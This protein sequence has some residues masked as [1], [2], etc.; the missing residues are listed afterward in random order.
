MTKLK[1]IIGLCIFG[2]IMF[3]VIN[4]TVHLKSKKHIYSNITDVP[5]C[6]TGIVLGAMVSHSGELSYILKDRVDAAIDLYKVNKIQRFLLSGDHGL[7]NYDEVNSMKIY[8]LEKGI[9]TC[10]IFLDHAGFDT[11]SSLTR[12]KE[13]FQVKNAIIISQRFHLP[14]AVYI[15]RKKGINAHGFIADRQEYPS[16]KFLI[17]RE[18]LAN[19]KAYFEILF[20]KNPKFLGDKIPITGDSKLSYD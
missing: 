7:T 14:R 1:Y 20:H 10:D 5:S 6:Y 2:A 8:L 16:I 15:A 11:Y 4:L 19:I 12:A 3:L 13:I 17:K 18:R 9:D